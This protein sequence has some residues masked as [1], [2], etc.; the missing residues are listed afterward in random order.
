MRV[1]CF[2]THGT[3]LRGPKPTKGQ[4]EASA[5]GTTMTGDC[6]NCIKYLMLLFNSIMALVGALFLAASVWVLLDTS[7]LKHVIMINPLLNPTIYGFLILGGVLFLLGIVGCT[8]A[9]RENKF[10]LMVSFTVVLLIFVLELIC[11]IL[12]YKNLGKLYKDYFAKELKENY[13]EN[14]LFS[15]E[16]D[17]I[18][19]DFKCCGVTEYKDFKEE[20]W[21]PVCCPNKVNKNCTDEEIF[22]KGC[23]DVLFHRYDKYIYSIAGFSVILLCTEIFAMFLSLMLYQSLQ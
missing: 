13:G 19:R 8:G 10:L 17:D 1:P 7:G 14:L 16:W 22:Q 21:P 11:A 9:A 3:C 23:Y 18:M 20:V 15:N 5:R 6:L 4:G 12:L 2:H